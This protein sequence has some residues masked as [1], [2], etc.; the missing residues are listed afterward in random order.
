MLGINKRWFT[1]SKTIW[2]HA[3]QFCDGVDELRK[4]YSQFRIVNKSFIRNVC[5]SI[6]KNIRITDAAGA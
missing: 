5:K 1:H 3:G 2:V 6:K 4:Y